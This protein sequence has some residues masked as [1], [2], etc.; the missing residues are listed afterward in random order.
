MNTPLEIHPVIGLT[1][2]EASRRLAEEG[3]NELPSAKPRN[4]FA[5]AVSVVREP[6][7]MLL[8]ACGSIYL[9]LG[10]RQ[11]A[12]MLLGFVFVIMG[13]TFVQ[14]RKTERALTALR[15]LSSP[16]ALVIREGQQKRNTRA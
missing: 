13:I 12:L 8:V 11:D 16:R 6:M 15:D 5:I 1:D 4:V 2:H 9:L 10:S 7:F 14:E 3:P